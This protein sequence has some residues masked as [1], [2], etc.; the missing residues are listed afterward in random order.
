MPQK[1]G[2]PYIRYEAR[3]YKQKAGLYSTDDPR[4]SHCGIQSIP[5]DT[6]M[7]IWLEWF[8][9]KTADDFRVYRRLEGEDYVCVAEQVVYGIGGPFA[10]CG[11]YYDYG[12]DLEPGV[13]VYYKIV[14][15]NDQGEGW[16][17]EGFCIPFP[18]LD[19][20]VDLLEPASGEEGVPLKPTFKWEELYDIGSQ[21]P[22]DY[23]LLGKGYQLY[24]YDETGEKVC[25][26]RLSDEGT[27][28]TI[29]RALKPNT[30]YSWDIVCEKVYAL[31]EVTN[32]DNDGYA[33]YSWPTYIP[34]DGNGPKSISSSGPM[35][36]TTG[37][38]D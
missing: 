38:G 15:Y 28:I 6:T 8:A 13:P 16:A 1:P 10:S 4:H 19:L 2:D 18:I 29:R 12:P 9:N 11:F 24:I 30:R 36:F 17:Y 37:A 31:Y 5:A 33:S 27:E 7:Y 22:A 35:F 26:E 34:G 25:S 3:T 21:I 20:E 14:P 32:E 23:E